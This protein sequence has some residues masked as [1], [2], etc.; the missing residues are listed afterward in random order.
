MFETSEYVLAVYKEKSFSKAAK[1]LY[2]SQPSLSASIQRI[3]KKLG[4]PIFDRSSVPIQLTECGRE[5][6]S[7]AERIKSL[8]DD[9]Q[10]YLH[11]IQHL[12]IGHIVLGGSNL[13]SSFM[14]PSLITKFK[15][16]YPGISIKLE[17]GNISRL[18]ERMLIGEIDLLAD[19]CVVDETLFTKY[20]YRSESLILAVPKDLECNKELSKYQ[21]SADYI[22]EGYHNDNL[23]PNVP[24]NYFINEPFVFL[25]PETDSYKRGMKLCRRY[26]FEPNVLLYLDQ[27]STA[28]NLAC[29]GM[30]VTFVSDTII[31]NT[32]KNPNI[33]L[34]KLNAEESIRDIIFYKKRGKY[35]SYAIH[36]FLEM[37]KE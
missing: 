35:E 30:G 7:T 17:E 22:K 14:M 15:Y 5:Y 37:L 6:I 11:N 31:K 13:Y 28:Y 26:N 27:Q 24:L 4:S 34:Y 23:I 18:E 32:P 29:Y 19:S 10:N 21:V 1:K 12:K 25:K 9:F 33:V 20:R 36:E 16:R 8:E 3:E 2:I